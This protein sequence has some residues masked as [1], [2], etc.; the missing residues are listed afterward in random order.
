[1]PGLARS[2]SEGD[3]AMQILLLTAMVL[4]VAAWLTD[5]SRAL[6]PVPVRLHGRDAG[7]PRERVN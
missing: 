4:G 2:S 7:R 3:G 6:A 5:T 1:M